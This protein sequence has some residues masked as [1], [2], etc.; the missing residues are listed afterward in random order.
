MAKKDPTTGDR[1]ASNKD[2]VTS[3]AATELPLGP[4]ALRRRISPRRWLML[5]QSTPNRPSAAL[6]IRKPAIIL[7]NDY[8]N[9]SIWNFLNPGE[10]LM[11][12]ISMF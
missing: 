8:G 10:L 4:I 3:C 7:A 2:S 12:L 9:D 5:Y 11:W 6:M 1:E